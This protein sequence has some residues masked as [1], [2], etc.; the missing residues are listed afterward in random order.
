CRAGVERLQVAHSGSDLGFVTISIGVGSIQPQS[1]D[2]HE[3]FIECT[4]Q[5][6]YQ[7]K[8]EGRNRVHL[9]KG[10][11]ELASQGVAPDV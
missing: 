4:D 8:A 6:L 11:Q 10:G 9:V 7:A 2:D 5:A 1:G 3:A